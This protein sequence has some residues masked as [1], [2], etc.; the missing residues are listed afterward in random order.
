M[1]RSIEL[2]V[3]GHDTTDGDGVS[4]KR[5]LSLPHVRT[6]DPFLMLDSF[7]TDSTVRGPG[8]PWH[9]HRG[10]IT[11]SYMVTGEIEH[12]DSMGNHGMIGAGGVQWM[13]AASGIVHQE[14]P[15]PGKQ[16]IRGLQFWLNLSSEEKMSD[17]DYGDIP[18]SQIPIVS[19]VSGVKVAILAGKQFD[20]TG[21]MHFSRTEP[22]MIVVTLEP[23]SVINLPA[24]S[25]KNFFVVGISGN[26]IIGDKKIAPHTANLLS[27]GDTVTISSK[28]KSQVMLVGAIP[29]EEPIAWEGPIVMNSRE[30]LTLAFREFREG[31]FVKKQ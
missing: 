9:P 2:T 17:P 8:F 31:T 26:A 15:H 13:K 6:F 18:A 4:L 3:T 19:P 1:E 7:G 10:I 25:Q 11:I 30:E 12:E 27:P 21:P 29:L 23:D 20:Y 5:I 28:E 24:N 14:M 22:E 16:G